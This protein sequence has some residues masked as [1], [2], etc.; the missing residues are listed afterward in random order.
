MLVGLAACLFLQT[1]RGAW[2]TPQVRR[3]KKGSAPA[4]AE[5]PDDQGDSPASLLLFRFFKFFNFFWFFRFFRFSDDFSRLCAKASKN[6]WKNLK[7]N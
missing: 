6:L 1:S 4:E 2:R 5:Q 7:K 3:T